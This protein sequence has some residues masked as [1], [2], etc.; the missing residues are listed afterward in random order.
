ME[1]KVKFL[2]VKVNAGRI[3]FVLGNGQKLSFDPG[4]ANE[5]IRKQAQFHGFNQK[6]RDAAA[7]YS[8]EKDFAGAA[9]EMQAVID[10][11]YRGE[12]NRKG[13]AG[14]SVMLEDLAK[15]IARFKNADF[16][17]ALAAVEKATPEQRAEWLKNK[18][19]KAYADQARADRLVEA[20]KGAEGAG[21]LEIEL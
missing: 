11:L 7:G 12:W 18:T 14:T 15:A 6:I 13:G 2:E 5:E 21:D 17:K 8:K 1:E 4:A 10:G 3:L 20:A 9:A 19:V 16:A